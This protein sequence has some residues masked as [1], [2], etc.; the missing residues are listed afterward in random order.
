M[1][2]TEKYTITYKDSEGYNRWTRRDDG[3]AAMRA[4]QS[5]T[6]TGCKDF[7]LFPPNTGNLVVPVK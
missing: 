5:L 1:K 2:D 4:I 7:M 3:D 6:I